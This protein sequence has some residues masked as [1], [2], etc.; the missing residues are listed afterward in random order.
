MEIPVDIALIIANMIQPRPVIAETSTLLG[1][2][3]EDERH[4]TEAVLRCFA[5]TCISFSKAV[6][7]RR[8]IEKSPRIKVNWYRIAAQW[9][10]VELVKQM[11]EASVY[12]WP[13]ILKYAVKYSS[14]DIMKYAG[15]QGYKQYNSNS[16]TTAM[17]NKN[18]ECVKFILA[19]GFRPSRRNMDNHL[20]GIIQMDILDM[21]DPRDIGEYTRNM[22]EMAASYGSINSLKYAYTKGRDWGDACIKAAQSG[23]LECVK[24]ACDNNCGNYDMAV[25]GA[26][27]SNTF[28][29]AS[30]R[31][32]DCAAYILETIVRL[33]DCK[34]AYAI[35][36]KHYPH[37]RTNLIMLYEYRKCLVESIMEMAKR[38]AKERKDGARQ[39]FVE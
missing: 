8:N 29:T 6:R 33:D 3:E 11:K 13:S 9:N 36:S 2:M 15:E 18:K 12:H 34:S 26:L 35:S 21:I 38:Y 14:L 22:C 32:L 20:R 4:Q 25:F 7:I 23:N 37:I 31:K 39:L 19:T 17:N 24:F 27:Y 16:F 1:I 5:L 10:S 30:K 28:D